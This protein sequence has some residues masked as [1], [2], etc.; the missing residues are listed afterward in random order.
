VGNLLILLKR[1]LK[2]NIK[3]LV[4]FIIFSFICIGGVIQ[5]YAFIDDVPGIEKPPLYDQPSALELW[6][7]WILLAA[8]LHI[9]GA[10]LGL[11]WLI[12]LFPEFTSG[13]K[14]PIASIVF[15]YILSCWAVY[16]WDKWVR[17]SK[18]KVYAVITVATV[19]SLMMS[20][21]P[22][23]FLPNITLFKILR[24]ISGFIFVLLITGTYIIS[25]IGLA[26]S[27]ET[28][29]IRTRRHENTWG[30]YTSRE[31]PK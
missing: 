5:T 12:D 10:V 9:L 29:L 8:P 31:I 7:P 17:D 25:L 2:P 26:Y 30:T 4:L 1:I 23:L 22:I 16:S 19:I 6:F 27:F 15:S 21:L 24:F 13:F 3:V 11:W 14:I 20:P 28:I 18:R